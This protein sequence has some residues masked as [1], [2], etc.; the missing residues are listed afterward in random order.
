MEKTQVFSMTDQLVD[1]ILDENGVISLSETIE[2]ERRVAIRDLL[3]RNRFSPVA[4][5]GMTGKG[6]LVLTLSIADENLVFNLARQHGEGKLRFQISLVPFRR[7]V[8]EYF[9]ICE[10]YFEATK[11]SNPRH[12]EAI[13]MGRRSVHDE[14]AEL[15][16]E[17][18]GGKVDVDMD[19]ARRLFTL[20]CVLHIRA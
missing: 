14:A 12:I 11:K 1:I 9:Q 2:L 13:D 18:L 16:K 3:H 10:S 4:K 20:I 15:L 17:R 7:V 8:K 5:G 6:P 19:T